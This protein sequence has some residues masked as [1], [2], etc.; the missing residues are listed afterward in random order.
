MPK[1]ILKKPF[2]PSVLAYT[3]SERKVHPLGNTIIMI[4]SV[5]KRESSSGV[6]GNEKRKKRTRSKK[7]KE[8]VRDMK[9]Q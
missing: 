9:R 4:T 6:P 8:R 2:P 5:E 1:K 7:V 3:G